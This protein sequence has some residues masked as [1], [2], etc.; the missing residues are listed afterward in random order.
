MKFILGPKKKQVMF[1]DF[2]QKKGQMD[3]I[4]SKSKKNK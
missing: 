2:S 3:E 4:Y 1:A